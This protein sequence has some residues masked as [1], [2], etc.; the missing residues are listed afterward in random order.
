MFRD[1]EKGESEA[2]S[3]P[4]WQR[5]LLLCLGYFACAWLGRFIS[6]PGGTAVSYWLPGGLLIAVLL[7]N[8]TRDWPWL[9]ASILPAN[10]GFDL[11]HDPEPHWL[12]LAAFCGANLLQAG[13][14]AWLV[15]RWIVKTPR[16]VS[17]KEFFGLLF[18]A[19]LAAAV[20]AVIGTAALL[21]VGFAESFAPTWKIWWG[22]NVMAVLVL[23]PLVLVFGE[24]RTRR[25]LVTRWS[26][27]RVCEGIVVYGGMI[28]FLLWVLVAG[29]GITST[30]IPVL[31]FVM[32]AGLRF[33]LPGATVMVFLLAVVASLLTTHFQRGLLP[34]EIATN[35]YVF[36]LQVFVAVTAMVALV[37]TIVLTERNRALARLRES[38]EHFQ[39]LNEAA[40]EGVVI[41]EGGIVVDAN[42]Q[43]AHMLGWPRNEI[44]G[45]PLLDFIA[46]E[47]RA[48]AAES[49]AARREA[50]IEY[51]LLR[52][53]GGTFDAEVQSRTQLHADGQAVGM[54]AVRDVTAR[55]FE[56]ELNRTQMTVLE[57]ISTGQPMRETLDLLL[58]L[59]EAQSREMHTSILLLGEDGVHMRHGAAPS[60]PGEY[61]KSI[62]G[63]AIGPEVGCCGTAAWRRE[64][65]YVAEIET[66]PLW[67]PFKHLV[68]PHGLRAC[69]ST[70]I[71][72]AQKKVLGTFAVYYRQPRLPDERHKRLI[73]IAT[74]TAAVCIAKDRA[75]NEHREAVAREQQSRIQYTFQLIAAQ[76]AE[77]K[78]IAAEIHDSLGQNLLLVKNLAQ[79]ALRDQNPAS[80]YEQLVGINN[81]AA[82]CI[83]EARQMSRELHPYQLEHLG[84]KRSLELLLEN[85][86]QATSGMQFEWKFDEVAGVFSNESA[87]NLYRVV[88]ESLNNVLKHSHAK[89][90]S[91]TLER[92]IHELQLV[93][94]DDG[95]GFEIGKNP[96]GMGLRNIS[97]R[98]RMLGGKL[99]IHSAPGAGARLEAVIPI[100]DAVEVSS[101]DG[102]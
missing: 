59:I 14:G 33:G 7:V 19:G 54:I 91:V 49:I 13:A 57:M 46:P 50:A 70:P 6:P 5:M 89:N 1:G 32:W 74:H 45:R 36:T 30:K 42:E 17:L 12:M 41:S 94:R 39:Q 8:P 60:L 55:K 86:A 71:F 44:I 77:R 10:I 38:R 87:T 9:M 34:E 68:L 97:E 18:F 73:Q 58:R 65:V 56:E 63:F 21:N 76:E 101:G 28:A 62:D 61:V 72:D 15:R 22:G 47:S 4:L 96:G 69:W 102:I 35:S 24:A 93:I 23:S 81:L 75:E 90:V 11:L 40:F 64:A 53:D 25:A 99:A 85:T 80:A 95:S 20:S 3:W 82:Q 37:P 26:W 79:I 27:L 66:D 31:V 92:D 51:R 43:C 100:A 48:V 52:R 84:L 88:Q 78:R 2:P 98:I 16:L 29:K 67:Q 83:A